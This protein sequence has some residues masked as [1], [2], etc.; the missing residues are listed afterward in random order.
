MKLPGRRA[1]GH[2]VSVFHQYQRT[3]GARERV[4]S[5]LAPA[6]ALIKLLMVSFGAGDPV[7]QSE[8]Q[9]FRHAVRHYYCGD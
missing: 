1:I 7:N 5:I 4:A 3:E 2:V 6:V 8:N 9:P